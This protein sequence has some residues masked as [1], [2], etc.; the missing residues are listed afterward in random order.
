MTDHISTCTD[1]RT[2]T[3]AN[4]RRRHHHHH[5]VIIQIIIL[6][7]MKQVPSKARRGGCMQSALQ[8]A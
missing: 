7:A 1:H 5:I 6:H 3:F 8:R 2:Q 4:R